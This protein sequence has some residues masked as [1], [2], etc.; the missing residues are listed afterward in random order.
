MKHA[1]LLLLGLGAALAAAPLSPPR[2]WAA[3]T[4]TRRPP[5][6]A[7]GIFVNPK[8]A[9]MFR[10]Q[11]QEVGAA[12]RRRNATDAEPSKPADDL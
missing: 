5:R 11:R 10:R 2:S 12:S 4:T 3:T 9:K 7:G 1:Q 6:G 8:V